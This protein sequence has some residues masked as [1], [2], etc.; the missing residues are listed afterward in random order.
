MTYV[1]VYCGA[2]LLDLELRDKI[3]KII[4]TQAGIPDDVLPDRKDLMSYWV[5][6]KRTIDDSETH[7]SEASMKANLCA[8]GAAADLVTGTSNLGLSGAFSAEQSMS[9]LA[10][11][12]STSRG[13]SN[14]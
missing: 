8:S 9:M 2:L 6:T 12:Q 7:T 4:E 13:H 1:A 10:Y 14:L 5:I 3:A 11:Q